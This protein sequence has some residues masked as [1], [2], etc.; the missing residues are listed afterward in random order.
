MRI[1]PT[2][3][4]WVMLICI[5]NSSYSQNRNCASM[6][7]LEYQYQ[8]DP[9]RAIKLAE[10]EAHT[11]TILKQP[12]RSSTGVITIPVVV[13]IVYNT[14]AE[15]ISDEQ[16]QTQIDVLNQDFRRLNADADETWPQAAD[17]E[18]E[19][20]LATTD[21]HGNATSGITRT[22]TTRTSFSANDAVKYTASGGID[23][24]PSDSYL[25]IWVCDISG[26]ILGYAQF[27]GG[28]SATDG[29]VNDF[30]YFGTIGSA[31]PPFNRGRTCTHEVGHYLNL[32]HIWGD[33]S[34][35]VDDMVADTPTSD[36]PNYG[37]S[38]GHIS[39]NTVDM[40]QNYMDYS[41]DGCMNLFTGG[42]RDRMRAL[43]E[44]GGARENLLSS[45]ACAP[46]ADPTCDD[47]FQNGGETGID[48]GGPCTT[49][50]PTCD[51]NLQNGDETGVDCGGSICAACPC[52][53]NNI[54]LTIKVDNYPEETTWSLTDASGNLIASG[55]PYGDVSDGSTL[56]GDF[57]VADGCYD[58]QI[59]DSFGDGICCRYGSGFYSITD[60][61]GNTLIAGGE[62]GSFEVKQFCV[63]NNVIEP[64][65]EDGIQNGDETGQDCGGSCP[66]IC[67]TCEDGIQ[68]GDETNVDCGGSCPPCIVEGGQCS[69]VIIDEQDFEETWG[70][71]NDGGSDCRANSNDQFYANSGTFCVRLRDNTFSSQM[72]TDPLDLSSYSEVTVDFS[73][74]T[75]SMDN[76]NEDFWLQIAPDGASEFLTVEEW[77]FD[78]E[79]V[80]GERMTGNVVLPGPFS[81]ST[82]LRFRCDASS[83]SD[84][85]YIDDVIISGCTNGNRLSDQY[86][87]NTTVDIDKQPEREIPDL[88]LYPNPAENLLNVEFFSPAVNTVHIRI[89]DLSGRLLET[90]ES[91]AIAGSN[92][93]RINTQNLSAGLYILHLYS[94]DLE[95]KSEKFVITR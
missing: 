1:S 29:V 6:D 82:L 88:L 56:S 20:C 32:R 27:P 49:A 3:F 25:N 90:V 91:G 83:N 16:I 69:Y 35:S 33:G 34:C 72:T 60:E 94:R 76:P 28:P 63:N 36:N 21:P 95:V 26:G 57:C 55:G 13:H 61:N 40:I 46:P 44:N 50:C 19:F 9:E 12:F 80:N 64:S 67:P 37:C 17:T 68:N 54:T 81:T 43:F 59:N 7:Y 66:G 89:T 74:I 38:T 71:W 24:W 47:G 79:F 77:N 70:I 18:I 48:C 52:E 78:D 86:H 39:C 45:T 14:E 53:G 93:I 65:C 73:Y 30:Q 23:A 8:L 11:R 87:I 58:F 75:R 15:N 10:V 41:D 51:D 92:K 84:W 2:A 5:T 85:V 4:C 62:F 22:Q 42:Q 31:Q